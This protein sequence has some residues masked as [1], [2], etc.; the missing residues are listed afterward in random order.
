M[1]ISSLSFSRG[2]HVS[3]EI[4][5]HTNAWRVLRAEAK[6]PK[7]AFRTGADLFSTL[8]QM[9]R[10]GLTAK[11]SY[12]TANRK[13]RSEWIMTAKGY[14]QIGQSAPTA[15]TAPTY[16]DGAPDAGPEG[17]APTAPTSCA[18]GV[19][20]SGAKDDGAELHPASLAVTGLDEGD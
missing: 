13:S 7:H 4:S 8:R 11:S 10:D 12:F 9:E 1:A 18:G 15:P 20:D 6:F 16:G 5:A 17:V 3:S 14:D 19:G 2:E